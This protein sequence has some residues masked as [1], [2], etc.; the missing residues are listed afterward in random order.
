M[1]LCGTDLAYNATRESEP[2]SGPRAYACYSGLQRWYELP[3]IM[4]CKLL[5]CLVSY[6]APRP[7]QGILRECGSNTIPYRTC[8]TEIACGG[9]TCGTEIAYGGVRLCSD[10]AVC[11]HPR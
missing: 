6:K 7:R 1:R 11:S 4:L 9:V 5:Y 8:S 2:P 10:G 3:R